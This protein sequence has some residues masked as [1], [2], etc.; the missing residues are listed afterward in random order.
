[1][2]GGTFPAAA[3]GASGAQGLGQT[4]LFGFS[5]GVT[6]LLGPISHA[7]GICKPAWATYFDK[8]C[9]RSF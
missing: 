9:F 2:A 1:M 7:L 5:L 3:L 6:A 8:Y 4:S